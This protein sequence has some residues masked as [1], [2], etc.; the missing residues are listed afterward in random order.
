MA[1]VITTARIVCA[2]GLLICPTFSAWFYVLYIISGISDVFDG[3]VARH[4]GKETK[5]GAQLD[6]IAD[7]VFLVIAVTKAVRTIYIPIWVMVWIILIA[8]MKS[9]NIFIG[10]VIYKRFLSEHTV[11]NKICGVLLFGIPLC[12]GQLPWQPVVV[13]II[14]TCG[15][16][17]FAAI[18]EGQYIR[19]GK[20]IR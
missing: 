16:A 8:V 10:F 9:I 4:F 5:C 15:V 3:I 7:I 17:T 14:L 18:Q 12:I 1:N 11:M 6:T 19:N 2:L 20:E 13:L